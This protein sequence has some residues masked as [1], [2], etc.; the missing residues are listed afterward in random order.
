MKVLLVMS[1]TAFSCIH[2][3]LDRYVLLNTI[4]FWSVLP[5]YNNGIEKKEYDYAMIFWEIKLLPIWLSL[6]K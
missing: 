4:Q 3:V 6:S 5:V 2:N 1:R